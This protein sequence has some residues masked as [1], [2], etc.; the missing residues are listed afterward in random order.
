M[1]FYVQIVLLNITYTITYNDKQM[2][3]EE[4]FHSL[5]IKNSNCYSVDHVKD[6][7]KIVSRINIV[8]KQYNKTKNINMRLMLNYFIILNN[9]FDSF[10]PE[11]LFFKCE[12]ETHSVIASILDFLYILPESYNITKDEFITKLLKGL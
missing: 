4:N 5:V 6:N 1:I 2:I 3:T 11:L 9:E 8:S 12:P 7:L 10:L